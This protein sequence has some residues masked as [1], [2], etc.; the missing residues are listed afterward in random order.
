MPMQRTYGA[1]WELSGLPP[2]PLDVR[3]SAASPDQ[4]LLAPAVI[5]T[6][7]AGDFV[8]QVQLQT[9]PTLPTIT[10]EEAGQGAAL[11]AAAAPAAASGQP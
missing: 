11:V 7:S 3:V 9:S 10:L 4:T 5:K 2:P 8:S 1:V 6:A